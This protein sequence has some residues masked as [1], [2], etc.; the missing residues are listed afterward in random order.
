MK[1][2]KCNQMQKPLQNQSLRNFNCVSPSF[3]SSAKNLNH[4]NIPVSCSKSSLSRPRLK[5]KKKKK[6]KKKKEKLHL[7]QSKLIGFLSTANN[8]I[9]RFELASHLFL[10]RKWKKCRWNPSELP[11]VSKTKTKRRLLIW[12]QNDT[13]CCLSVASFFFFFS[14]LAKHFWPF[15]S[16]FKP[17]IVVQI[18]Y[19]SLSP[20]RQKKKKK[21]NAIILIEIQSSIFIYVFPA[22]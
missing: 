4:L 6:R 2:W 3:M 20:R 19:V 7:R 14:R 5:E 12:F 16:L 1:R 8:K 13:F 15:C 11:A 22:W 10:L 17:S 9:A 21:C 18:P